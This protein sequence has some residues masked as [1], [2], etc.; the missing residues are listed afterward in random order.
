MIYLHEFANN[1]REISIPHEAL[2]SA[3]LKIS[4]SLLVNE[5]K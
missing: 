2:P 5:Y 3:V 1:E 4:S